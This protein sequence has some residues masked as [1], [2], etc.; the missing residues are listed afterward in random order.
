MAEVNRNM[1]VIDTLKEA[2]KNKKRQL[3]DTKELIR[4]AENLAEEIQELEAH[5]EATEN[6]DKEKSK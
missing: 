2:L 5:I 3:N 1:A 6:S 4:R